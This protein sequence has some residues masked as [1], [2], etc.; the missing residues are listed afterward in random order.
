LPGSGRVGCGIF[1]SR[2]EI[3][4]GLPG[5]FGHSVDDIILW[6]RLIDGQGVDGHRIGNISGLGAEC[7]QQK[8]LGK[9]KKIDFVGKSIFF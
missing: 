8:N 4:L 9:K 5:H 2:Y 6:Q 1:R 3:N 7:K